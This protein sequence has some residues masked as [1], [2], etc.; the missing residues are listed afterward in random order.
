MAEHCW[1]DS[2]MLTFYD[3]LAHR[4]A[5]FMEDELFNGEYFQQKVQY[6]GLRNTSFA[7]MV[8]RSTNIAAKCRSS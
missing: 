5:R 4:C 6:L 8:A 1:S 7:T 2:R 3:D